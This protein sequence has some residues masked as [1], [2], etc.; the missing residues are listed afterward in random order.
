VVFQEIEMLGPERAITRQP[1]VE[2]SKRLRPDAIE[3]TLSVDPRRDEPRVLENAEVL[4]NGGLAEAEIADELANWPLTVAQ[5]LE[6]RHTPWFSQDL[7][8]SEL[9]HLA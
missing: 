1:L 4:R 6:N 7:Q 5:Q 8:R 9:C 3:P 2:I